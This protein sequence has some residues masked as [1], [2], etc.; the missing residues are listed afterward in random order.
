MLIESVFSADK[1]QIVL[2]RS[3]YQSMRVKDLQSENLPGDLWKYLQDAG[4]SQYEFIDRLAW[5]GK[6]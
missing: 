2:A 5:S 1:N 3:R 6:C 4:W